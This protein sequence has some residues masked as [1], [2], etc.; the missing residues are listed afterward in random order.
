MSYRIK[1]TLLLSAICCGLVSFSAKAEDEAQQ[2]RASIGHT[3]DRPDAVVVSDPVVVENGYALADWIQGD[4]GGRALLR[5]KNGQWSVM[6]CSGDGIK[7]TEVLVN[8]GVPQSTAEALVGK[9]AHAE[10][11]LPPEQVKIFGLFG[12]QQVVHHEHN[13]HH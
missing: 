1:S 3:F 4:K 11:G 5:N 6:L 13:K 10:G 8:A 9:L 7:K 12:S 2:I